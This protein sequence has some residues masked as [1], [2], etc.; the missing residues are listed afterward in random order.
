MFLNY[1]Q[2]MFEDVYPSPYTFSKVAR[3]KKNNDISDLFDVQGND[4]Q[5]T[6]D[7][8]KSTKTTFTGVIYEYLMSL[9]VTLACVII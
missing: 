2:I 3:F 1:G 4:H 8:H 6:K 9:S 7:P 5:P